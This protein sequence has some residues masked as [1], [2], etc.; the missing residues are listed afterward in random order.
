MAISRKLDFR[1]NRPRVVL[2]DDNKALLES[3]YRLL[4]PEFEI[5]GSAADG[6]T[7]FEAVRALRPDVV[8]LD[9]SM[10]IECGLDVA[11]R[12]SALPDS[13]PVVFLSVHESREF[14]DAAR[15]AGASGYVFKRNACRD[16]IGVLKQVLAGERT[17]LERTGEPE[18]VTE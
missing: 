15:D 4:E 9:I 17:I 18:T 2:A 3:V 11:T 5:V 1:M 8:V 14:L 10:P 6:R 7:A 12:L 16:L 13:P